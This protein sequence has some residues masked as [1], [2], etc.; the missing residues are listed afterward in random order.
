MAYSF[1]VVTAAGRSASGVLEGT[2]DGAGLGAALG[3]WIGS[4]LGC[5]LGS[6]LGCWL[7]FGREELQ[8]KVKGIEIF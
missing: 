7:G 8:C 4:A 5:W 6:A 2:A 1:R 3:C